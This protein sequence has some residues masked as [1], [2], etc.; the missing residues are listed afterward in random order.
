MSLKYALEG[1]IN[2][3]RSRLKESQLTISWSLFL[4]RTGDSGILQLEIV[5][6]LTVSALT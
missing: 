6:C 5:D 3:L 4:K 2:D 1:K